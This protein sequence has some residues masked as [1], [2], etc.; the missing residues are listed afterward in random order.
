V[1]VEEN[2]KVILDLLDNWLKPGWLDALADDALWEHCVDHDSFPVGTT[3]VQTKE[4]IANGKTLQR[5]P[6]GLAMKA[7]GVT[8]EGDRVAVE[9]LGTGMCRPGLEAGGHGAATRPF[10]MRG[11]FLFILRDGKVI[12]VN[13]YLDTAYVLATYRD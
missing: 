12:K 13:E 11:H 5:M 7:L 10:N 3:G 4:Q 2:K 6:G 1:S 9:V 8:A